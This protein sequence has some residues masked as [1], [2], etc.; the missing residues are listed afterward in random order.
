M[1][2]Y[3]HIIKHKLKHLIT[4]FLLLFY[5]FTIMAQQPENDTTKITLESMR[6]LYFLQF[7]ENITWINTPKG[8]TLTIGILSYTND[9]SIN[10]K[11]ANK[12]T[13]QYKVKIE[14]FYKI[15]AIKPTHILYIDPQF[16]GSVKRIWK[17]VQ[18]THTLFITEEYWNE[19]FTMINF[20]FSF[21]TNRLIYN[22]FKKNINY[23]ELI[24]GYD[25]QIAGASAK[26]LQELLY[27]FSDTLKLKKIE[28]A[29][30]QQLLDAKLES[31]QKQDEK[32]KTQE[33]EIEKQLEN[34]RN[35]EQLLKDQ[36]EK[37]TNQYNLFEKLQA[38]RNKY[39][40]EIDQQKFILQNQKQN[41]DNQIQ[42]LVNQEYKIRKS[43]SILAQ[44]TMFIAQKNDTINKLSNDLNE[45][46]SKVNEQTTAIYSLIFIF[47]VITLLAVIL[48]Y[49]I[50][51][52]KRIENEL[53]FKNQELL[54]Q[55][56]EL[57]IQ[58]ENLQK[59]NDELEQQRE[60]AEDALLELRSTQAQLIHS[61]KMASIGQLTAGIAHEI[62]NPVNYIN[63]GI[64]A[65]QDIIK[66]FK[67]LI[68]KIDE[69][70]TQNYRLKL[71]EINELK[72]ELEYEDL[73]IGLNELV[74]SIKIG[75]KRTTEI[76]KGLRTFARSGSNRLI[77]SDIHKN[78]E[79]TLLMV[80]H[81][82]RDKIEV[83]KQ[84][85]N[86]PEI[87]CY[88]E[89]LN[90]V[91]MNLF[92]NAIQAING[93]GKITISTQIA[94]FEKNGI[95]LKGVKI[96]IAD[97]GQG[98][99]KSIRDKIFDPFFTTKDIGEGTGL[100]LSISYNIIEEHNGRIE[101]ESELN[102]GTVFMIYLPI[103]TIKAQD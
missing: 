15:S 81:L 39:K 30:L 94:N 95:E 71:I 21:D 2:D 80:H 7:V 25:I 22:L 3:I 42:L 14:Q 57:S 37:Y 11:K 50:V 56:E 52:K 83:E 55:S 44:R 23:K 16:N 79:S 27:G 72:N 90:Q 19:H 98:I 41:V 78:L 13:K 68:D 66:K 43:D 87:E 88:P 33:D 103:C 9:F 10:L 58:A 64:D 51:K 74:N 48:V 35:Q 29:K 77:I 76:V 100:G 53:Q 93:I 92:V 40:R 84:Y 59:L 5:C 73:V 54:Q 63:A 82:Y 70:D 4:T 17:N 75:A 12:Y 38:E 91:F 1:A 67:I 101:F 46:I 34:I 62:N 97:T 32:I 20:S 65:L 18:T 36:E 102:K 26:E 8:D 60:K 45:K 61:E 99:P 31:V 24:I 89:K 6:L 47:I 69:V 28:Q 49:N 85:G 96:S 86:I